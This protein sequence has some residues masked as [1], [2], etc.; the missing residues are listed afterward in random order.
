[1]GIKNKSKGKTFSTIWKSKSGVRFS[2]ES[3]DGTNPTLYISKTGSPTVAIPSEYLEDLSDFT[4]D[5]QILKN[6]KIMYQKAFNSPDKYGAVMDTEEDGDGFYT[7]PGVNCSEE[8]SLYLMWALHQNES[9]QKTAEWKLTING[10]YFKPIATATWDNSDGV[11]SLIKLMANPREAYVHA[12]LLYPNDIRKIT[13]I[14]E[15]KESLTNWVLNA[16]P[17]D[18]HPGPVILE[19]LRGS[20]PWTKD[21]D[22]GIDIDKFYYK[23]QKDGICFITKLFNGEEVSYTYDE[24]FS[25]WRGLSSEHN[26][27]GRYLGDITPVLKI[28]DP[29]KSGELE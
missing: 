1:M 16:L 23:K 5:H 22:K 4:S 8:G 26:N 27:I 6:H 10:L 24:L 20:N 2:L 18:I 19:A 15:I 3:L 13:E 21:Q 17:G 12:A 25:Q 14:L 29:V 11:A 9:N 7:M 28:L